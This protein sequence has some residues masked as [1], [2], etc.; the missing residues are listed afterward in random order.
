VEAAATV[1]N[2]I[3]APAGVLLIERVLSVIWTVVLIGLVT[4]FRPSLPRPVT[5]ESASTGSW[6]EE[7]FAPDGGESPKD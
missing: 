6:M 5:V 4:G 3:A 1:V 2:L 7:T